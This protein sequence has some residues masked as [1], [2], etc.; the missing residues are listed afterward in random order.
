MMSNPSIVVRRNGLT[1]SSFSAWLRRTVEAV[2]D[3]RARFQRNP[4]RQLLVEFGAECA[5]IRRHPEK[6]VVA[7]RRYQPH[8]ISIHAD[9]DLM[10]IFHAAHQIE[11]I[12][13]Q[14]KLDHVF[15]IQRKV[16]AHQNA[17]AGAER[18]PF[19]MLVLRKIGANAVGGRL[20][21]D[22]HV[23]HRLAA[24][25]P[26]SRKITLHQRR[27]HPENVGDIV[28]A[29]ALVVGRQQSASASTSNAS[30]S[31]IAL[32]YSARFS[33]CMAACP[34]LGLAAAA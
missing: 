32:A 11:S 14:P 24:D 30:K 26:G 1:R 9:L 4:H 34:G 28:E 16:V 18:Q 15:G 13:P 6:F 12:A 5:R 33:R 7:A 10:G 22:V 31:R 27:R 21:G 25:I 29:A 20:R 17:A 8:L 3:M 23:A 2:I 19:D